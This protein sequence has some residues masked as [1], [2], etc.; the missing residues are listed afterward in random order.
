MAAPVIESVSTNYD[1]DNVTSA[2][3]T[4]PTGTAENDLLFALIGTRGDPGSWTLPSGWTQ[5]GFGGGTEA[6]MVGA[7]KVA[8][9]SEGASYTFTSLNANEFAG[10]IARISGANTTTPVDVSSFG[11]QIAGTEFLDAPSVTTTQADCLILRAYNWRAL[12]AFVSGP[13]SHTQAWLIEDAAGGQ[14]DTE[15]AMWY[16]SQGSAGST[17]TATLE[18]DAF[19]NSVASTIAIAPAVGASGIKRSLINGGLINTGLI[20]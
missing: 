8:G 14:T 10:G 17:G 11:P 18:I 4:K 7:W 12:R 15:Q 2:V 9:A 5:D 3:F 13:S 20:A 1:L 16:A 19:I 6:Y